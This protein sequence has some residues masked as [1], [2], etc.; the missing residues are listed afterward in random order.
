MLK[1]SSGTYKIKYLNNEKLI[2]FFDKKEFLLRPGPDCH[3][4]N[5]MTEELDL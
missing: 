1:T 5:K 4:N 2:G 3:T